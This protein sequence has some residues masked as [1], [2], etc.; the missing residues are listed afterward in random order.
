MLVY[1]S[2]YCRLRQE[3]VVTHADTSRAKGET[4]WFTLSPLVP[5]A[6]KC[7]SVERFDGDYQ[8]G[9]LLAP[10][11]TPC[12]T[13]RRCVALFSDLENLEI[14]DDSPATEPT[15]PSFVFFR[16]RGLVALGVV[17]G[18]FGLVE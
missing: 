10:T 16:I 2:Q 3:R 18:Q 5:V 14:E 9:R 7:S 6:K 12:C 13:R 17:M 11:S 15:P 4:F 1:F 8:S